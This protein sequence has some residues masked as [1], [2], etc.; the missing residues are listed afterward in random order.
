MKKALILIT[1][2]VSFGLLVGCQATSET[3][4]SQEVVAE[5]TQVISGTVSYRERIALPENAVVTVTL[6]DISLADA[7]S[8]V[9]ATQEFTTDGKQVPFAF[10][11]SYDNDKIKANHRYNMRAS[12]HVD[13]KLRFTT[14]TIKSVITDVENTQQADLRLVGVR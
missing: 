1:S 3:N 13:G 2:L 8:T 10:E 7:P 6:E 11:L 4:A 5:N 9:I 12:I 14:D